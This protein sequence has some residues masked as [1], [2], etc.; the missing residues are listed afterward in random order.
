MSKDKYLEQFFK[1]L[2]EYGGCG[3][4]CKKC[5]ANTNEAS[6]ALEEFSGLLYGLNIFI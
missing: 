5:A 1:E 2:L 4:Y 6:C 3:Y